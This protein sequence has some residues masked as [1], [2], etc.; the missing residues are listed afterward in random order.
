MTD[1]F[2]SYKRRLRDR[3]AE[4][5]AELE[6]LGLKVWYDAGLDA[7]VPFQKE[8]A[9][10]IMDARSVMV[11]FSPDVFTDDDHAWVLSEAS[12]GR[13]RKVLVTVMLEQTVLIPPWNIY[14]APSLEGWRPNDPARREEWRTLLRSIG[15][16]V[17][18]LGL[19]DYDR[20]VGDGSLAALKQWATNYPEDPLAESIWQRVEAAELEALKKRLEDERFG[21]KK[22]PPPPRP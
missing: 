11:C 15:K 2:I 3:V 9:R 21:R 16:H 18:R 6:K 4:I 1:V 19:E 7:G 20:A 17:G 10:E 5:A 8:I 12:M 13:D 22:P 14:N